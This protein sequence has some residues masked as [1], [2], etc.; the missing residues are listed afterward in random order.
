MGHLLL[1]GTV[2]VTS[3]NKEEE[4]PV[5]PDNNSPV[6]VFHGAMSGNNTNSQTRTSVEGELPGN[7]LSL[8]EAGDYIY[9]VDGSN[10]YKSRTLTQS[11]STADFQAETDVITSETPSV[12][13]VGCRSNI[14]N[15][16][17]IAVSQEQ[18]APNNSQ[19]LG[20]S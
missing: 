4:T 6:V 3:C 9:V 17:N 16:V 2:F 14:H 1:L 7:A 13:Y 20:R 18:S 10:V 15:Q 11:A 19:H 12:Y 5:T 8:W